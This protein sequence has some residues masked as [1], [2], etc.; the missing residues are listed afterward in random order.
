ME[1]IKGELRFILIVIAVLLVIDVYLEVYD[2]YVPAAK[3]NMLKYQDY[4]LS[5]KSTGVYFENDY[6]CVWVKDRTEEE[7]NRTESHEFC[8]HLVYNKREH[9][10]DG[11]REI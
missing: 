6:Y 10:C 8:H 5:S 7:I 3:K 4:N 9:F 2:L 11:K 1:R